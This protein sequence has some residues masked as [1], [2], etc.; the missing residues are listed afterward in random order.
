V[1][2]YGRRA[3]RI[4]AENIFGLQIA[5]TTYLVFL[6]QGLESISQTYELIEDPLHIAVIVD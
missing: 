5:V 4:E 2:L 6:M 3:G 1:V